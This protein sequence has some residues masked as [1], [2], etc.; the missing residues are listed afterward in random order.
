MKHNK[1]RDR[2]Q[3]LCCVCCIVALAFTA[4]C[5]ATRDIERT[6]LYALHPEI[7]VTAVEAVDVTLGV[8]P[9][10]AARPY[11]LPMTFLNG[12]RQLG[13]RVRDEWAE[14]PANTVTRALTDALVAANRFKDVGNAADMARP[15]LLLTGEL[16]MFHE[17]RAQTP[18]TAELEVRIE[19]RPSR[20][21]GGLWA[22]TLYETE[23]I[24]GDDAAAFAAAMNKALARL[25]QQAAEAI[26]AVELPELDAA[27]TSEDR[28][29]RRRL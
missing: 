3:R 7:H 27:I 9:L 12:E 28:G 20:D 16:R 25:V 10:F 15:D 17:N 23:P 5:L 2:S 8:R 13:H 1:R 29:A 19:L 24:Q 26:A 21:P 4:G 11:A 6:R 18:A 22:E 14:P